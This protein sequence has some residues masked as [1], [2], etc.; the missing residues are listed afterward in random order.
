MSLLWRCVM[1]LIWGYSNKLG[2]TGALVNHFHMLTISPSWPLWLDIILSSPVISVEAA[3]VHI[4]IRNITASS[5]WQLH[6][7]YSRFC[8]KFT[9]PVW[10]LECTLTVK[11]YLQHFVY[12]CTET[13]LIFW[14][15]K[16]NPFE[17]VQETKCVGV[18]FCRWT[19]VDI[20]WFKHDLDRVLC[21]QS[22]PDWGLNS[23]PPDHGSTFHVTDEM[24]AL[25]TR[26]SLTW[27]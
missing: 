6:I 15:V 8:C 25:T 5:S 2:L 7:W 19:L 4:I 20:V 13:A 22:S 3:T 11:F 9:Q 16:S 24:P 18:V 17:A 23:W 14:W 1:K 10:M 26:P 21:T 27:K 12:Y